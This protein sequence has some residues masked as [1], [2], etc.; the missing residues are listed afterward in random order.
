[1]SCV[2]F[3][4]WQIWPFWLI[5]TNQT[6]VDLCLAVSFLSV[7]MIMKIIQK[8]QKNVFM[9]H[10]KE[11]TILQK[12]EFVNIHILSNGKVIVDVQLP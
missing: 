5:G 12:S 10:Q 7:E 8:G 4:G 2:T 1:M 3:Y 6:Q 11:F 9:A